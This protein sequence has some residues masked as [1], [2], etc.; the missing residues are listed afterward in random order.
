VIGELG[1]TATRQF[2]A[3]LAEPTQAVAEAQNSI[4]VHGGLFVSALNRLIRF[5]PE[6][7]DVCLKALR[8]IGAVRPPEWVPMA[9]RFRGCPYDTWEE[10]RGLV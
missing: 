2:I 8:A 10:K 6:H 9:E 4:W 5:A 3:I 1:E 7:R